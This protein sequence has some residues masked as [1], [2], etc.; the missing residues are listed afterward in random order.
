MMPAKKKKK[1]KINKECP[2]GDVHVNGE[3]QFGLPLKITLKSGET[4]FI[5][6][7]DATRKR[8]RKG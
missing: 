8:R 2:V 6:K 4:I 7:S 3:P 1:R 5:E